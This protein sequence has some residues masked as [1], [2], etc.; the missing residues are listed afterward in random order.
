MRIALSIAGSDPSGGA[1]IQADLKTFASHGVYGVSAITAVTAQNTQRV[2]DFAAVT[3]ELIEAQINAITE[4]M[5]VHAV[6]T[7]MLPTAAIVT[8][9]ASITEKLQLPYLVVDPVMLAKSGDRLVDN[10]AVTAIRTLLL[11]HAFVV[12]PNIPE[13]E[14]LAQ[15]TIQSHDDHLEAARRICSL[16]PAAVVIKGGHL[17][18]SK[19][20]D[21]A[22]DGLQFSEFTIKRVKGRS[23]HGTGCTFAAALAANLAL[24]RS[25]NDA[26]PLVQKYIAGAVQSGI[27]VGHGYGPMDHFWK[28]HK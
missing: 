19:I 14:M 24:G 25:L 10:D 1:G 6:K 26:I 13:A 23:I 4:D 28:F 9:V 21:V 11:P 3:P 7:G 16:G 27:P 15:M 8:T 22:Y 17:S 2:H 12:T 18:S 20:V 5:D